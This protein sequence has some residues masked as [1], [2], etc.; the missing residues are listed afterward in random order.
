MPRFNPFK[1]LYFLVP[2]YNKNVFFV[3]QIKMTNF[4]YKESGMKGILAAGIG[5]GVSIAFLEASGTTVDFFGMDMD[6]P[7]VIGAAVGLSSVATD[8]IHSQILTNIQSD[9]KYETIESAVLNLGLAGAATTAIL[10]MSTGETMDLS[11]SIATGAGSIV[12]TDYL[13]YQLIYPERSGLGP[14]SLM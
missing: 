3:I 7:L 8:L 2:I 14:G 4:D 12:L 6:T 9:R 1:T 5:Y 13:Y 11:Y 10:S